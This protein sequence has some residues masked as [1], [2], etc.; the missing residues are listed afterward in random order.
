[1]SG[2]LSSAPTTPETTDD[3]HEWVEFVRFHLGDDDYGLELGR[4]EQ[5]L[6]DPTVTPVPQTGPAVAGV[7]NL[8][9]EIPVVVDGRALL[10]LPARAPDAETALLLLD[11]GEGR[12]TGLLVDD[13][14]GIDAHHVEN[15]DAPEDSDWEP[16]V[17]RRWFRAV[18][19]DADRPGE[20]IGVFDLDVLVAKA[21]AQ[22]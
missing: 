5:I 21:R 6:D 2:E 19:D 10:E 8:G 9:S 13:V 15:I 3:R 12:P 14:A 7:T 20:P 11:R 4:V 1:M 22:A 18:V 17:R 16:P